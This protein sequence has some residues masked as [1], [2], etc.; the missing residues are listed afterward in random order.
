VITVL[1][2]ILDMAHF[3]A[4]KVSPTDRQYEEDLERARA[5]SLESLALEKFRQD[6]AEAE[7]RKRLLEQRSISRA[8]GTE[9]KQI[10]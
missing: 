10:Q 5:L 6:K 3:A 4:P 1:L 2:R 9:I 8:D 7:R